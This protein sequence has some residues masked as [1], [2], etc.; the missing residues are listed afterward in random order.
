[1]YDREYRPSS[2]RTRLFP[3]CST[4]VA[5]GLQFANPTLNSRFRETLLHRLL[6]I[7]YSD[8]YHTYLSYEDWRQR[9]LLTLSF[10][11]LWVKL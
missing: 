11:H 8:G 10:R 6:S 3:D 9:L 2:N 5:A 7:N 1:M 4:E